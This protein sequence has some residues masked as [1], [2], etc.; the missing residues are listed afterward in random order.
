MSRLVFSG[1]SSRLRSCPRHR[2]VSSGVP[3]PFCRH[4]R[5]R[6]GVLVARSP[7]LRPAVASA[8]SALQR[9]PSARPCS[10]TATKTR[11]PRRRR[12]RADRSR[13]AASAAG[14]GPPGTGVWFD[15][16]RHR[17]G[18]STVG[19]GWFS[20]FA[21]LGSVAACRLLRQSIVRARGKVFR[22]ARGSFR[23]TSSRSRDS[24][25]P[26]ARKLRS[27]IPNA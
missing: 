9:S 13:S 5:W 7:V 17:P 27:T 3:V 16:L 2:V 20:A 11:M 6:D 4:R 22:H 10:V 8:S 12:A 26:E 15:R 1:L 18:M 25:A 14:P 19:P 23:Y 21:A 24:T